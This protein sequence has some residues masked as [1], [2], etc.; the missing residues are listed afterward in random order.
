MTAARQ[1]ARVLLRAGPGDSDSEA[2]EY[3]TYT[4][5]VFLCLSDVTFIIFKE[6]NQSS[7][8]VLTSEHDREAR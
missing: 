1:Q 2:V 6:T 3:G 8:P 7:E 4:V 5:Y